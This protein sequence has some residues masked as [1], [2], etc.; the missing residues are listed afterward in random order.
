MTQLLQTLVNGLLQSGIYALVASGLALAVGVVGIVNFAHGEFAMVGAFIAYA[1]FTLLGLDPVLALIP[2]ALLLAAFG[3]GLYRV[4]LRPVLRAPELNQML[5]TFGVGIVLT[6]L[7]IQLYGSTPRTL[8]V[9]YQGDAIGLLGLSAGIARLGA[10]ALAALLILGLYLMLGNTRVGKAMR[11]VAQNRTGAALTGLAVDRLYLVAFSLA[12]ALAGLAGVMIAVLV[13]VSPYVGAVYT[14]KAFAIIVIAGL[15]NLGGVM[16]AAAGLGIA[17][18]LVQTYVP[19][20]GGW[21][22]AVFFAMIFAA[23]VWRSWREAR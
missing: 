2:T 18:A 8:N 16:L 20:G 7:A 22:E 4:A 9:G 5:L 3:A 13:S 14:L 15:G 21:S 11:A 6:N 23:L 10:F 1:L 19:D 17:E 12:S